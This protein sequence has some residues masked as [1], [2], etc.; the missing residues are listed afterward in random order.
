MQDIEKVTR[1][2]LSIF[3]HLMLIEIPLKGDKEFIPVLLDNKADELL[4][5]KE[6]SSN[7]QIPS[8][9]ATYLSDVEVRLH[10]QKRVKSV[11]AR[12]IGVVKEVLNL[13]KS[14]L[15]ETRTTVFGRHIRLIRG[16]LQTQSFRRVTES[17]QYSG[18]QR[19]DLFQSGSRELS[20]GR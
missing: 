17:R 9:A 15:S 5:Q 19:L 12:G 4:G 8:K 20:L 2:S 11:C 6:L 13:R 1:D 7:Y 16:L 10:Y 3:R 14:S 18:V